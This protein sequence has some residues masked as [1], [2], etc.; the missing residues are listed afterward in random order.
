LRALCFIARLVEA[1][2]TGSRDSL[3]CCMTADK[4]GRKKRSAELSLLSDLALHAPWSIRGAI[5]LERRW[6][7]RTFRYGYLVTTSPQSRTLPW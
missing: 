2:S 3:F 4:C 6:S 1:S 5:Y 7:S